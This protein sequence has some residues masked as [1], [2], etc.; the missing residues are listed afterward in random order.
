MQSVIAFH[1]ILYKFSQLRSIDASSN[2][3]DDFIHVLQKLLHAPDIYDPKTNINLTRIIPWT[4]QERYP[5]LQMTRESSGN[6]D[7][8]YL[9]ELYS[10]KLWICV[11]YTMQRN[12]NVTETKWLAPDTPILYLDSINKNHWIIVNVQQAGE[13]MNQ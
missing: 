9:T 7:E 8:I 13:Y 4:K 5:V 12:P 10:R 6:K 11:T 2:T 1:V 3:I